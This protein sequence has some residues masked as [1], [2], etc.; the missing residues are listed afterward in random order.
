MMNLKARTKR[1]YNVEAEKDE[2]IFQS[3]EGQIKRVRI[4]YTPGELR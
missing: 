3:L 4:T 2:Q 1:K